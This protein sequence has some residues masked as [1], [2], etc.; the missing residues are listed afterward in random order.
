MKIP[1]AFQRRRMLL[2][3]VLCVLGGLPSDQLFAFEKP[4]AAMLQQYRRNGLYGVLVPEHLTFHASHDATVS[5]VIVNGGSKEE[6]VNMNFLGQPM[7][8]LSVTNDATGEPMMTIGPATPL[9]P[10]AMK[11]YL[12]TLQPSEQLEVEY[13]L[14]IF[15][16]ELPKG[17]YTVR[18]SSLPSNR[19]QLIIR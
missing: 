5:A 1:P 3:L 7:Y 9:P 11:R 4:D 13:S 15:S 2:E 19:V 8:A 17:R 16:P 14:H 12:R 18:M 6:T 10:E